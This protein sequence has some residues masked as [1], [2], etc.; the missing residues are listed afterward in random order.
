MPIYEAASPEHREVL[1]AMLEKFHQPLVEAGVAIDLLLAWPKL[2]KNDDPTGPALTLHGWRCAA[3]VRVV[4]YKQRVKGMGDAEILLD[5]MTWEETDEAGREALMDHELEHLELRVSTKKKDKG[6]I[7]RDDLGRPKLKLRQRD[8]KLEGFHSIVRRHGV[9]AFEWQA[10]VDHQVRVKQLWL[11][12]V[13]VKTSVSR[14]KDA[15]I[16]D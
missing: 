16:A 7:L 14:G 11:P 13:R 15:A 10:H 5:A 2:D 3:L 6:S 4:P 8:Y 9:E 12:Y 1:D